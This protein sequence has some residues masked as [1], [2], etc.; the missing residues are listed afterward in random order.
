MCVCVCVC[1]QEAYE[2]ERVGESEVR[3]RA[4]CVDGGRDWIGVFDQW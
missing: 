1:D 4:V 3:A 2:L